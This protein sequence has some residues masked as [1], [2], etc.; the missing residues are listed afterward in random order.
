MAI[1]ESQKIRDYS[2]K[3]SSPFSELLNLVETFSSI[4]KSSVG[5]FL[6]LVSL[7]NLSMFSLSNHSNTYLTLVF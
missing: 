5:S 4:N 7:T 2:E 3:K 6:E 1:Y